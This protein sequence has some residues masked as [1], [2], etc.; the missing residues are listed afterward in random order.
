MTLPA[1]MVWMPQRTRIIDIPNTGNATEDEV[2]TNAA[3]SATLN[4]PPVLASPP[5]GRKLAV[6]GGAPSLPSVLDELK[7]WDGDIWAINGTAAWLAERGIRS[8]FFTVDPGRWSDVDALTDGVTDAL[9]SA[10]SRPELFD[11]LISKGAD[12]RT[13]HV[14][15]GYDPEMTINGG[16]TSATRAPFLALKM[17]YTDVS[18]FACEGC[19]ETTSH[20]YKH[21]AD[22]HLHV[23]IKAGNE[24]FRTDLRMMLQSINLAELIREFPNFLH[25]RSGGLLAGMIAHPDSWA[26]VAMTEF[27]ASTLDDPLE[28]GIEKARDWIENGAAA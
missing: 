5:H 28:S 11:A 18:F 1:G 24:V 10:T 19:F 3:Y 17:G 13:F 20:A 14:Y 26:I 8:T 16:G 25:D 21:T 27:L 6:V 9:V 15:P 23:L 12:I 7:R 4:L 2:R 22:D